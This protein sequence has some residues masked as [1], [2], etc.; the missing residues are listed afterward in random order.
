M[1]WFRSLQKNENHRKGLIGIHQTHQ[2]ISAVY[3]AP[4]TNGKPLIKALMHQAL[5]SVSEKQAALKAFVLDHGLEGMSC[6]YVLQ[7]IDYTLTLVDTPNVAKEERS[8]A[9][10][11]LVR[12][13]INF[14]IDEAIIDSFEIPLPRARDNIKMSYVAI[15]RRSLLTN[16]ETMIT[17]CGLKV[18]IIDIPELALRNLSSLSTEEKNGIAL[19]HL[20]PEDGKLLICKGSQIYLARNLELRGMS[21]WDK[22]PEKT[23]A[24]LDQLSL[25]IQ[26]SLDYIQSYFRQNL[27]RSILLTPFAMNDTF[28][29]ILKTN[30]GLEVQMLDL[31][32]SLEFEH[33]T[34]ADDQLKSLMALG[35]AI[36]G[37]P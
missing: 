19:I 27:V 10:Q 16:I 20:D 29:D 37:A 33:P 31:N 17:P 6:S 8:R 36:R 13:V 2:G 15:M 14:P 21:D 30:L 26:R 12:E 32:Q 35:G 5:E 23:T 3:A 4:G 7:N 9:L 24:L 25:E 18:G 22:T 11:W 34:P 1:R 28:K